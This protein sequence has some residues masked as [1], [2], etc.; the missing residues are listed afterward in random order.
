MHDILAYVTG[1]LCSCVNG[2]IQWL[3]VIFVYSLLVLG[4][5]HYVQLSVVEA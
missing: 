1:L 5:E 4:M 3:M 2:C